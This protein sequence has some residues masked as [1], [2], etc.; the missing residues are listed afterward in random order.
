MSTANETP[1]SAEELARLSPLE[2]LERLQI[3][4]VQALL[5]GEDERASVIAGGIRAI[6]LEISEAFAASLLNAT[7]GVWQLH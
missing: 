2:Q 1:I 5:D 3:D 6:Q 4:L 7:A